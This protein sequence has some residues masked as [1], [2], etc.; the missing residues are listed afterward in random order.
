MASGAAYCIPRSETGLPHLVAI[1][2]HQEFD[3]VVKR[4]SWRQDVATNLQVPPVQRASDAVEDKGDAPFRSFDAD[5][6]EALKEGRAV[7]I[8]DARERLNTDGP[9]FGARMRRN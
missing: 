5:L 4:R 9:G 8:E 3:R 2:R 6:H 1:H 7:E